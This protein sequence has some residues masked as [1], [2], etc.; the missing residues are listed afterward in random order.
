MTASP[1]PAS[2]IYEGRLA[3]H[4]FLPV[5]HRFDYPLY[6]LYLDLD[7]LPEL[8]ADSWLWS[9]RRPALGWFRRADY[10]GP[11][12]LDLATAVRQLVDSRRSSASG[13]VR[14]L[15]H[16]RTWGHCFNPV[17]FYYCFDDAA[18]PTPHHIVAEVNNTPWNQ[19]HAYVLTAAEGNGPAP[20]TGEVTFE[21]AKEFHVS[22]FMPMDHTYRWRF[23]SPGQHLAVTMENFDP[24]GDRIFA[25]RLRLERRELTPATL[26]RVLWRYPAM[27]LRIAFWIYWQALR[28]KRKRVP[29]HPHPETAEGEP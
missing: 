25:A 4:R 27:T 15:T 21:L 6:L 10:L 1:A 2:A 14:I 26:R 12:T 18:A 24:R 29:F 20:P 16:A 9:A 23:A 7:E 19:R 5:E 22:P 17:S 8:F 3:H 11:T 28:L 13:P